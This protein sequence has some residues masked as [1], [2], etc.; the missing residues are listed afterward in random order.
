[1]DYHKSCQESLLII[2]L[3]PVHI[4]QVGANM[5]T[6]RDT[7]VFLYESGVVEISGGGLIETW[8]RGNQRFHPSMIAQ[9]AHVSKCIRLLYR[10]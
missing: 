1:M 7:L 6:C 2:I 5:C 3:V 4:G 10:R 9:L 8:K